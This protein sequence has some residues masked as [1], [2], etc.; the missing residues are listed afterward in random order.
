M[1]EAPAIPAPAASSHW[2]GNAEFWVRIIREH[3]DRYRTELTDKAM[4]AAIGPCPGLDVLDAGCGEGYLTREIADLGSRQV[5]GVDKS[6]ALIAAAGVASAGQPA[7][8]FREGDLAALPFG[9]DSFDLAVVNHVFN[10]L[11]DI[12]G[13]VGE[14]AR[15]LRPGSRLVILMLHPCFYGHRAE[16]Q[17]IRRTLPVADYFAQRVIEQRFEVDGI[18]SPDPTVTWVRPLEAYT[19]A[20]TGSGLCITG[21]TEP[22]PSDDQLA[23]SEWWREN[24]PRP[25][26]LLITARKEPGLAVDR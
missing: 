18:V 1:T 7:V 2:E 22:H 19:K 23:A 21:L 9:D 20:I 17:E 16:R 26:F 14:L 4:L 11:P 8:R 6:R 3:R 13:P 10:D 25:L 5:A 24:F 12:V 15:V